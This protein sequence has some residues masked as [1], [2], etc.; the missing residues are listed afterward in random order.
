M[1]S[2]FFAA[3]LVGLALLP[4]RSGTPTQPVLASPPT[5]A[6]RAAVCMI[7]A[8]PQILVHDTQEGARVPFSGRLTW[9]GDQSC[10]AV[11]IG[12]SMVVPLWPIG[13]A[14]FRAGE[15]RGVALPGVGNLLPGDRFSGTAT[16]HREDP[17]F[18]TAPGRCHRRNGLVVIDP[19]GLSRSGRGRRSRRPT[20]G[21]PGHSR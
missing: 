12:G 10:L 5:P 21:S 8:D 20:R 11:D 7:G 9:V 15:R 14:P 6:C 4:S 16:W 13:A 18:L 3:T 19:S 2:W 17:M 1:R